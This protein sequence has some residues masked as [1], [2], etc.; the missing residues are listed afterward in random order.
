[1]NYYFYKSGYYKN[2]E[3]D[4]VRVVNVK[5][6]KKMDWERI[7]ACTPSLRMELAQFIEEKR[8]DSKK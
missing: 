7:E 4:L 3:E 5:N 1:M 2:I 6:F 8:G